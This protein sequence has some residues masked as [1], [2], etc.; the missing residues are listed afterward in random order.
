M[1]PTIG[2]H[3]AGV[4]LRVRDRAAAWAFWV[5]GLGLP[6]R[7]DDDGRIALGH[8]ELALELRVDPTAPL[9]PYPSVG[10]YHLAV[11]VPTRADLA[12]VARR[13]LLA[14]A[15][16]EGAADHGVSEALY[17]RDPERNG[18]EIAW[19]RPRHR[20]PRPGPGAVAM[21]TAPLDLDA[22]LA[23]APHPAPPPPGARLGHL[24]LHVADLDEAERF[25]AL[26]GLRV[27]QRSYPGARFLA[28]GDYH[29]H[30]GLNVWAGRRRA[31]P[32]ATGLVAHRWHVAPGTTVALAER[33]RAAG[34][35]H[36][37]EDGRL[38][39]EDPTGARVDL[40]ERAC[41]RTNEP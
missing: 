35:P 25:F 29:H 34:V 3:P 26:L 13:L 2:G 32:E 21:T 9:R 23:E 17:F 8:D 10:L 11:L 20:W 28:Y 24:H 14:G 18:L 40:D 19:D 15:L 27:T 38:R 1:G 12:A 5:E 7:A 41:A 22:L 16:F 6:V 4:T 33:L 37:H 39:V 31:P 30:L 36:R